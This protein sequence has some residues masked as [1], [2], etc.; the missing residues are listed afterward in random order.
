MATPPEKWET[1]KGLF[2]AALEHEPSRRPVLLKDLCPNARMR[3]EVERLLAEYDQ[4][5]SFLPLLY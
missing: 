2:E 1:V 4:A 3:A 5:R